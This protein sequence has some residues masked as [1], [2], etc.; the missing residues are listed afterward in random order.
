MDLLVEEYGIIG[1]PIVDTH[2]EFI[3]PSKYGD[4]IKVRSWISEW[5]K[6]ALLVTH[7]IYNKNK[8]SVKGHEIRVWAAPHPDDPQ[9]LKSRDIPEF[10][11]EKFSV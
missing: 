4:I 6:K 7:E 5:R 9:R 1:L 10:F 8:L 3:N 11:K 2:A